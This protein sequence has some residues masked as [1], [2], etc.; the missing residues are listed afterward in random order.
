MEQKSGDIDIFHKFTIGNLVIQGT[1][2]PV[3]PT[4]H[5]EEREDYVPPNIKPSDINFYKLFPHS[6]PLSI[7]IA[8]IAYLAADMNPQGDWR[9]RKAGWYVVSNYS[10]KRCLPLHELNEAQIAELAREFGLI[11]EE[12][13]SP[14][15]TYSLDS[16]IQSPAFKSLC[17]WVKDNAQRAQRFADYAKSG[18][19]AVWY[20]KASEEI[21]ST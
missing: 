20:E 21:S 10:G 7:S 5:S 14:D 12:Q 8:K 16:F 6:R 9:M 11:Y 4:I 3:G 17:Q 1:I 15:K 19:N 13:V 2:G 18:K